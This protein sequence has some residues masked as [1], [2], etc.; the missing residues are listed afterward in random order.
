MSPT[1]P[2]HLEDHSTSVACISV[3]GTLDVDLAPLLHFL[4]C[5]VSEYMINSIGIIILL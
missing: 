2:C 5:S 1:L 3:N 4:H